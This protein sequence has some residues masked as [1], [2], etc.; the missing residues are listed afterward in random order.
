MLGMCKFN[1][2]ML[3]SM[4][5][6]FT[7]GYTLLFVSLKSPLKIAHSHKHC[8]NKTVTL[9]RMALWIVSSN[10]KSISLEQIRVLQSLKKA[11]N[12]Y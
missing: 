1:S 8:C 6:I 9:A 4:H 12:L 11:S 7:M 2:L 5:A 10:T 3:A